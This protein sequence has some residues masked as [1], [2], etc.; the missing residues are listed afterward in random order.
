MNVTVQLSESP[1]AKWSTHGRYILG[2]LWHGVRTPLFLSL[3]IYTLIIIAATMPTWDVYMWWGHYMLFPAVDVYEISKIWSAQGFGHTPW[4]PDYCFGYGY[5]YFTLYG[6]LGFYVGVIFHFIL[7]LDYGSA[8]KLSFYTSLY[9]SGLFMYAFVYTIGSR[10]RWPRLA[11][12]ALAAATIYALTRYHLTDIFV[13][14]VLAESWAWTALPG[15]YWGMEIAR[16][17]PWIGILLVSLMYAGLLLSHNITALWATIFIAAYPL[18]TARDIKWPL[19]VAAGGLLGTALSAF[20]WYP[21]L[22]LKVL[23]QKAGDVASMWGTPDLVHQHAIFWRQH[24]LE[25]LG[26]GASIPGPNDTLGI[27][28][29]F[30][31]LISVFLAAAALFQ[32][33][34]TGR[35]RWHVALFLFLTSV[36]LFIMSPQMPWE[37]I[38]PVL[39]YVQF[40]WRLLIFTGFFGAAVV[41]MASPVVD[42]WIHPA[43]LTGL[44]VIFAI[45]T[46]PMVFMPQ[47]IKKMSP[48]QLTRWNHRWERKGLYGGSAI[49]E[50]LP[51]SVHGE[52]LKP[53]FLEKHPIPENRLTVLSGDLVCT[54]YSHR[55]TSYEYSYAASTDSEAQ[56]A[57]FYW[58]GWELRVDG[59][60]LPENLTLDADGLVRVKLP[61][62]THRAEVRYN[63]STEGKSARVVSSAALVAWL[64]IIFGG[65]LSR[66]RRG[67]GLWPT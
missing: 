28:I 49:Q 66:W 11:W 14:N 26:N 41:A 61:A 3:L 7:G 13:R 17:R 58:P 44:A 59:K 39:R 60:L 47:L 67:V 50:F 64:S 9:L 16:R 45:P 33:A 55:G 6:P 57:V 27:N 8:T 4:S 2:Q 25:A 34:L 35:Q 29:G 10:E 53:E 42:R 1:Q 19:S 63:L 65:I 52:Y 36:V 48:E 20:F 38:P 15:V 54:S 30:A 46:L 24:F 23:T 18:L 37:K 12:W 62:G 5:P 43:I 51:K 21:A 40:P 32:K 56:I 31:V 22:K